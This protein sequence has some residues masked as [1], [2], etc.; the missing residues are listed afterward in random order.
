MCIFNVS[1]APDACHPTGGVACHRSNGQRT[2]LPG[3]RPAPD[4][5]CVVKGPP[6]NKC[7]YASGT[8]RPQQQA[9]PASAPAR[10]PGD[11][12]LGGTAGPTRAASGA[13]AASAARQ[14][15]P[16]FPPRPPPR[17]QTPRGA[18]KLRT[19]P[20]LHDRQARRA[21]PAIPAPGCP[22]PGLR[23][24]SGG[25]TERDGRREGAPWRGGAGGRGR[26]ASWGRPRRGGASRNGRR[27]RRRR[28]R[29]RTAVVAGTR[30]P[31]AIGAARRSLWRPGPTGLPLGRA[32]PDAR[33]H[34]RTGGPHG[35]SAPGAS[36]EPGGG[37]PPVP[38][39]P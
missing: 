12:F 8:P 29:R 18:P 22:R 30:P 19:R 26:G 36:L 3:Q 23:R 17:F 10:P 11:S 32:R 1:S 9:R 38:R 25:R 35:I 16:T 24:R 4:R 15:P 5:W 20:R 37:C 6:R 2:W 14:P 33:T 13:T 31:G 21:D 7:V 34:G 27:R 39:S 28:R